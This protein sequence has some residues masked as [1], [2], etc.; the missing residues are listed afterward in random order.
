MLK[1]KTSIFW[2]RLSSVSPFHLLLFLSF[3]IVI[4]YSNSLYSPFTLDDRHT[5]IDD[6]AVYI[7]KISLASLQELRHSQF[8]KNRFIPMVTFAV[9]HYIFH[10]TG[11]F[12]QY[13]LTNIFIHISATIALFFL[14]RGLLATPV[15]A[16]APNS[17]PPHHFAFFVC[18]LW[19]LNPVQTNAV[20]YIVQRMASIVALFYFATAA[21]YIHARLADSRRN[22]VILSTAAVFTACCAFLSKENSATLPL[23]ILL[24]EFMF[25][26]PN[27]LKPLLQSVALRWWILLGVIIILLLPFGNSL[28]QSFLR[29]YD[30][31]NF[32]MPERL[33]TE[34][35]V[36]VY[37]LSL[38]TLPLPSR[39]N[40]D[41]DFSISTSLISPPTT[42][43]AIIF[44]IVL[45]GAAIKYR[46][47]YPLFSFGIF[48]YLLNL[49]IE[50]TVVPLEIIFEHRLYLP[51]AGYF[52]AVLA[53]LNAGVS[54]FDK[55][56]RHHNLSL[57]ILL[58]LTS[59]LCLSSLMT[60][61]RN[62]D[63]R[64]IYTLQK[65]S[66]QKSPHKSRTITNYG[67][68]LAMSGQY[69]Q[70][71]KILEQ[72]IKDGNPGDEDYVLATNNILIAY[73][74]KKQITKGIEVTNKYIDKMPPNCN[75]IALPSL[76]YNLA[77][78]LKD[79]ERYPDAIES[80]LA[81]MRTM[82]MIRAGS[83]DLKA[84]KSLE[85]FTRK[86]YDDDKTRKEL[87]LDQLGKSKDV[88]VS[89][90]MSKILLDMRKYNFAQNYLMFVESIDNTNKR[91][92][93]LWER[94]NTEQQKNKQAK[95][96]SEFS[97]YT[98]NHKDDYYLIYIN[99]A[100]FIIT[101]YPP[102]LPIAGWMLDKAGELSPEDPFVALY[103]L[104]WL[105]ARDK[106]DEALIQV[107]KSITEHPD[108]VPLLEMG[109]DIFLQFDDTAGTAKLYKHILDIYPGN[110][111]WLRYKHF[112]DQAAKIEKGLPQ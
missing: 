74:K 81:A 71:I 46:R 47:Q 29:G 26:S 90:Y 2:E 62:N 8:G 101:S 77:V 63:W 87:L 27:K 56:R 82:E 48:W 36:V 76:F 20:T 3:L 45:L 99:T 67:L 110:P 65:D 1:K 98:D 91:Y 23:A 10:L 93:A 6:P 11:S 88:A 50:S 40:L 7:D 9:N 85:F 96:M 25:L 108:F 4:S 35:R 13:H 89:L 44:L 106:F 112:I 38:L 57:I 42:I 59:T 55:Q 86:A 12:A 73:L 92:I 14:L 60:T 83:V 79:V 69:D 17:F 15:G 49:I 111:Q 66:Y 109:S 80:Q 28:W 16:R 97:R 53:I 22:R 100:R 75:N 41:H 34:A 21:L 51:S 31:R 78:A 64:D 105:L 19:A 104:R 61:L 58:L 43:L 70:S 107:K 39:L 94:F 37:Y 95:T 24:I 33:L 102:L 30:L 5:F 54:S 52:I 103:K 72:C 32:T 68:T 84:V 18:A